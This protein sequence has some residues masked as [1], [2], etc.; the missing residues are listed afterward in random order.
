[1][2]LAVGSGV[3]ASAD[4]G[5]LGG[6]STAAEGRSLGGVP[7]DSEGA[8]GDAG[9]APMPGTGD[10]ERTFV[11]ARDAR[12]SRMIGCIVAVAVG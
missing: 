10:G 2:G 3:G 6:V 8:A 7:T 4:G 9:A 11:G 12:G 1:V 5:S